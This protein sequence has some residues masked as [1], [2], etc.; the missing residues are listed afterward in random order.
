MKGLSATVAAL[1]TT[2][3]TVNDGR[4]VTDTGSVYVW[5]GTAWFNAGVIQGPTGPQGS[6]GNIGFDGLQGPTGPTGA[7]GVTGP[8]G[9]AGPTGPAVTSIVSS[10]V[11]TI[12]TDINSAFTLRTA[13]ANGV[14]RSISASGITMTVPNIL[15][16]GQR[17]DIVQA[18][19]GQVTFAGS[20]ISIESKNGF[21]RT[22]G[23][24]SRAT[25]M[26]INGSYYLFGDII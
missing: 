11:S 9:L 12:T 1:P 22:N 24:Y 16:D 19:N 8:L 14:V 10:A 18:G 5:S 6:Q 21:N 7:Q 20:N 4:Y 15:G 3:N 17:V 13:D 26:N 2:G 25:L 23:L